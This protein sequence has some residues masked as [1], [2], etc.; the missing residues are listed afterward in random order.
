M[1]NNIE[2][3]EH[4][5]SAV[6]REYTTSVPYKI[7]EVVWALYQHILMNVLFCF[8]VFLLPYIVRSNA[9]LLKCRTH[10][11]KQSRRGKYIHNLY[12]KIHNILQHDIVCKRRDNGK[13]GFGERVREKFL[14]LLRTLLRCIWKIY[15]SGG[16]KVSRGQFYE[17]VWSLTLYN[18]LHLISIDNGW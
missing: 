6:L 11:S 9:A 15:I 18:H 2:H 1:N 5:I 3:H 12:C 16:I 10:A 4:T 8:L 17:K 14:C 13:K 7:S